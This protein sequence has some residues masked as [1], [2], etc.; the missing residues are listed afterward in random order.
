MAA[1]ITE[2]KSSVQSFKEYRLLEDI[3]IGYFEVTR[4]VHV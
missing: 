3:H 4:H 1:G 2:M